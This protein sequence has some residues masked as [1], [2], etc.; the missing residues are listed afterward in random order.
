M[1]LELIKKNSLG[2]KN[3]NNNKMSNG[4]G[5]LQSQVVEQIKTI[6]TLKDEI[7]NYEFLIENTPVE[8]LMEKT[9]KKVEKL[10]DE[11]K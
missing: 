7:A 4:G 2:E 1:Q 8:I 3:P 9:L 11:K 6:Q 10:I 5:M